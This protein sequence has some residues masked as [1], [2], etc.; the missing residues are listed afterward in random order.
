MDGCLPSVVQPV[1]PKG[2]ANGGE[3]EIANVESKREQRLKEQVLFELS[4]PSYLPLIY[5]HV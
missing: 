2:I 4:G 1:Q 5:L 3:R